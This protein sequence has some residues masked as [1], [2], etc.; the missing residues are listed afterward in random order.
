MTQEIQSLWFRAQ[1]DSSPACKI[2]V[3]DAFLKL[4]ADDCEALTYKA[5]AV[6]ELN[7][8]QWA[9]NLCQQALK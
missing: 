1:R 8:P 9:I 2:T 4:R 6:L 3:Y 5:D 7:E